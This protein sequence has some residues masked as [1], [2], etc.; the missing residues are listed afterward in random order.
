MKNSILRYVLVLTII[1]VSSGIALGFFNSVTA[2]QIAAN[3]RAREVAAVQR[4]LGIDQFSEK[5][6]DG[7]KLYTAQTPDGELVAFTCAPSGF[8][9][10]ISLMVSV[11]LEAETVRRVVVLEHAETPGLGARIQESWFT[12]QF[13]GKALKDPFVVK[14]DVEAITGATI[15]STAVTRGIKEE[16]ARVVALLK[17]GVDGE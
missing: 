6:V 10:P 4:V 9:G 16:A 3:R 13:A 5:V 1:A 7:K 15:S 11:N 17:A 14:K 12:Q 8:S 2:E